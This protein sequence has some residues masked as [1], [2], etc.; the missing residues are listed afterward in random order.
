[1]QDMTLNSN[2]GNTA[3]AFIMQIVRGLQFV[4]G[5]NILHNDLKCD[6]VVLGHTLCSSIKLYIIDFGKACMVDSA[7]HYQLSK[8][9]IEIYKKEH[10]QIAP[11]LRDGRVS[12][13]SA[14]DVYA[15]GR[16]IKRICHFMHFQH[17]LKRLYKQALTYHSHERPSLTVMAEQFTTQVQVTHHI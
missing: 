11:D 1:M 3:L 10:S 17:V 5:K 12:Q 6:N 8:E 14:T 15:L 13:S 7:K 4:H 9:E 16:I 2:S